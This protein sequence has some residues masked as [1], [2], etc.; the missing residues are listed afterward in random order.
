MQTSNFLKWNYCF[1][2]FVALY[3]FCIV[4]KSSPPL[5]SGDDALFFM[6]LRQGEAVWHGVDLSHK[7]FFP[8]AGWNLNLVALFSTSPY[9]FMFGNALCF[10]ITAYCY[11]ALLRSFGAPKWLILLS[12][13]LLT[14]S[15]GYTKIITQIAFSDMT[16]IMFL[17]AFL[18]CAKKIYN[19]A[20]SRG[21]I[22]LDSAPSA[23]IAESKSYI[24][25]YIYIVCPALRELRYLSQRSL[26][27]FN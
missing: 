11:Y 2:A 14:L 16:Q 15:V 18:L 1:F 19:F 17:M 7:R 26:I 8:L 9:A 21:K 23:Q 3:A 22:A 5:M 10:I 12:F 24:Y 27:Y 25:I 20:E 4:Y 13:A 6:Q